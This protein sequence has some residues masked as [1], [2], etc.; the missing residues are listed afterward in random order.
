MTPSGPIDGTPRA[1]SGSA[2]QL[3]WP[4]GTPL[5]RHP[6]PSLGRHWKPHLLP[7]TRVPPGRPLLCPQLRGKTLAEATGAQPDLGLGRADPSPSP[8][9]PEGTLCYS[10]IPDPGRPQ[11]TQNRQPQAALQAAASLR[12]Q[13]GWGE[14]RGTPDPK[15]PVSLQPCPRPLL[16]FLR[17]RLVRRL[18][19]GRW[20][21]RPR[22]VAGCPGC[23][24]SR[25]EVS[26]TWQ[27][28]NA[29]VSWG[30]HSASRVCPTGHDA[31]SALFVMGPPVWTACLQGCVLRCMRRLGSGGRDEA[32]PTQGLRRP[33]RTVSPAWLGPGRVWR[34]PE[35]GPP[36]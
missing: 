20:R 21:C 14:A 23:G 15:G 27:Q 26:A 33:T 24:R 12:G 29:S 34:T 5:T 30:L 17:P 8:P 3:P 31:L 35:L 7:R 18:A 1:L 10:P 19:G 11:S 25:G 28:Q 9:P 2:C 36:P 22:R 16:W 4:V 32:D 6:L 13:R